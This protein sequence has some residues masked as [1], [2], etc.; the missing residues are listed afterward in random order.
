LTDEISIFDTYFQAA[1]K[2][3]PENFFC[4]REQA[5][6]LKKWIFHKKKIGVFI[7]KMDFSQKENWIFHKKM[8][9]S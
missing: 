9:F 2:D 6:K 4:K 5:R 3:G 1:Y 7:K 8:D